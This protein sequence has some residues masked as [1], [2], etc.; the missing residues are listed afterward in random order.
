MELRDGGGWGRGQ[1]RDVE[2]EALEF[3][4]LQQDLWNSIQPKS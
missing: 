4:V 1:E 3:G 2:S